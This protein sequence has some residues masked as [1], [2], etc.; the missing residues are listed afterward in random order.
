MLRAHTRNSVK[1]ILDVAGAGAMLDAGLHA[2]VLFSL[3]VISLTMNDNFSMH[4]HTCDSLVMVWLVLVVGVV[5]GLFMVR[6]RSHVGDSAGVPVAVRSCASID[7]A[8][9]VLLCS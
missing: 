5:P 4:C 7:L 6:Y 1:L 9:T 3:F 8:A 2:V